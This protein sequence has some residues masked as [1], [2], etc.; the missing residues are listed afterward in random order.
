MRYEA[1]DSTPSPGSSL[2]LSWAQNLHNRPATFNQCPLPAED[3]V[4]PPLLCMTSSTPEMCSSLSIVF[5]ILSNRPDHHQ[6]MHDTLREGTC[7]DL[8]S[9]SQS[10]MRK[11]VLDTTGRLAPVSIPSIRHCVPM[12]A[13][14]T[15]RHQRPKPERTGDRG[16]MATAAPAVGARESE[17]TAGL[18]SESLH[19]S[20]SGCS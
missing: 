3:A 12:S 4:T 9:A 18:R 14:M 20:E 11:I 10:R 17:E 1:R 7:S 16:A 19:T 13:R 5:S 6:R 15:G 2:T 8:S